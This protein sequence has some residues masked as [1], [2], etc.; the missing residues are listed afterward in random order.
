MAAAVNG[1]EGDKSSPMRRRQQQRGLGGVRFS[2]VGE[3]SRGRGAGAPMRPGRSLRD[4][5]AAIVL[6]ARSFFN[7]LASCPQVIAHFE[8]HHADLVVCDGAPDVTGL[9]DLDEYV[10]VSGH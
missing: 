10:Q 8:G 3:G 9:H 7:Q 6:V 2:R 1:A 4:C 5:Q